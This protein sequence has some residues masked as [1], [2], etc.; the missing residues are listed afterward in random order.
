MNKC[1]NPNCHNTPNQ[2]WKIEFDENIIIS[3][4]L[5]DECAKIIEFTEISNSSFTLIK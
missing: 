5:C 4:N 2:T 3:H 1:Q